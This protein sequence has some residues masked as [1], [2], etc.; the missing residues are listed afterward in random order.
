MWLALPRIGMYYLC[1]VQTGSATEKKRVSSA[2][3]TGPIRTDRSTRLTYVA[4]LKMTMQQ[5]GAGKSDG[6]VV[7]RA[8]RRSG[9]ETIGPAGRRDNA[10]FAG[11]RIL[12]LC[13]NDIIIR[14][15]VRRVVFASIT[16]QHVSVPA[17]TNGSRRVSVRRPRCLYR[18]V[19][20]RRLRFFSALRASRTRA[21]RSRRLDGAAV[22]FR[23][24]IG[25]LS[26]GD[27]FSE[28][29]STGPARGGAA[30]RRRYWLAVTGCAAVNPFSNRNRCTR[31]FSRGKRGI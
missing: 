31:A 3:G 28:R 20:R 15:S 24:K 12:S 18:G 29:R 11:T 7:L 25:F 16:V 4:V 27:G 30:V 13:N 14:T 2:D 19:F 26:D 6:D 23:A 21:K 17:S 5:S 22:V 10:R 1:A 9:D 8:R